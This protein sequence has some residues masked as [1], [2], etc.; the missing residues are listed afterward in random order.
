MDNPA[1][2]LG[3]YEGD[4][5]PE[6][7]SESFLATLR[8]LR[9][10]LPRD[11]GPQESFRRSAVLRVELAGRP[12]ALK[13]FSPQITHKTDVGG[14]ELGLAN[15]DEVTAAFERILSAAKQIDVEK[16][17]DQ[18]ERLDLPDDLDQF[19]VSLEKGIQR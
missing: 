5:A 13:V 15:E 18:A 12:V 1:L 10:H 3:P 8:G 16:A 11:T 19:V 4:V 17:V 7:R 14:V 2:D 9:D 6:L